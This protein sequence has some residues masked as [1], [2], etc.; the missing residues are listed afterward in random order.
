MAAAAV[1]VAVEVAGADVAR[2]LRLEARSGHAAEG[3]RGA[4]P[5]PPLAQAA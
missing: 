2:V 5:M 3:A 4:V 1:A